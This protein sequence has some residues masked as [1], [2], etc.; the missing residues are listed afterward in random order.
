MDS[1]YNVVHELKE[2]PSAPKVQVI[3]D[4]TSLLMHLYNSSFL[5][6]GLIPF[7]GEGGLEL[8]RVFFFFSLTILVHY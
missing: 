8:G 4:C 7:V 3:Q 2:T 6:F 1:Q 5:F